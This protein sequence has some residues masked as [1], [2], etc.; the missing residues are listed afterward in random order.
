MGICGGSS[1]I[2]N[3][4]TVTLEEENKKEEKTNPKPQLLKQINN[5]IQVNTNS[6]IKTI[7]KTQHI[8]EWYIVI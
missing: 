5:T 8:L 3:K 1:Q 6:T 4:Y 7:M 2:P